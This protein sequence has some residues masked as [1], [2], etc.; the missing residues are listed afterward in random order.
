MYHHDIDRYEDDFTD[1]DIMRI[2][3]R[4]NAIVD[5]KVFYQPSLLSYTSPN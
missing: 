1:E 2:S 3:A 4:A 5:Q